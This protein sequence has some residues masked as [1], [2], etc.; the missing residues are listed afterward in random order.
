[1]L[2]YPSSFD[3]QNFGVRL[4]SGYRFDVTQGGTFFEPLATLSVVDSEIDGF[5]NSG[6]R[7]SFDDGTSVRGRLG[8]RIGTSLMDEATT[9]EPFIIASVWREFKDANQAQINS[10]G[11]RFGFED[12]IERTWGEVSGGVNVFTLGNGLSGFGKVD[13]SF[14]D[15]IHGVGGQLGLRYDW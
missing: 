7:I 1:V 6:H 15:V 10:F 3:G 9:F 14:G 2:G 13:V 4:D 12:E 8:V 5:S 11:T